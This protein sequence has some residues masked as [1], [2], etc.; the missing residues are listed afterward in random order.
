MLLTRYISNNSRKIQ[1]SSDDF[2]LKGVFAKAKHMFLR[3][4]DALANMSDEIS[5]H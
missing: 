5:E 4:S 2:N 1:L 3:H